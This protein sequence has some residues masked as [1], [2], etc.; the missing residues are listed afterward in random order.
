V[1][2][3]KRLCLRKNPSLA[4]WAAILF[5]V[6]G[7]IGLTNLHHK[8]D[9]GLFAK[10]AYL[11]IAVALIGLLKPMTCA[12]ERV[13]CILLFVIFVIDL[14]VAFVWVGSSNQMFLARATI[15]SIWLVMALICGVWA[16]RAKHSN[17]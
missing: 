5:G 8:I 6:Y 4:F 16:M 3:H 14:L 10:I 17:S 11:I 12:V 2:I 1:G 7:M 13:L 9:T 15:A